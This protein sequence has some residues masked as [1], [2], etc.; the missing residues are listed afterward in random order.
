MTSLFSGF[1]AGIILA[2][3]QVIFAFGEMIWSPTA[4]AL[5]NEIAPEQIRGRYNAM[6]GLQWNF[7]GVVGP[8]IAGFFFA[9]K[10]D[11]EW[12]TLMIIGSLVGLLFFKREKIST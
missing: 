1:T 8:L 10:W 5:T 9:Q 7:A 3:S 4:P 11:I 6:M 2:I 12:I